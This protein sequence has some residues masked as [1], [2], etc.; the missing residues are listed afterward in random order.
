MQSSKSEEFDCEGFIFFS[1]PCR[2]KSKVCKG[3]SIKQH[4]CH[5]KTHP[6]F[7]LLSHVRHSFR[8]Q[9][10]K[11]KNACWLN[12]IIAYEDSWLAKAERFVLIHFIHD[13]PLI[14]IKKVR[15]WGRHRGWECSSSNINLYTQRRARQAERLQPQLGW[16]S[17]A[18]PTVTVMLSRDARVS[19][20]YGGGWCCWPQILSSHH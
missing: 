20:R 1:S 10:N 12:N 14:Y 4:S 16:H 13:I 7:K 2:T 15:G 9:V 5:S 11:I 6:V 19:L 18:F 8:P 17:R 3:R